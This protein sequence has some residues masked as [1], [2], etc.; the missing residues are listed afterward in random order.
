MSDIPDWIYKIY[1]GLNLTQA[2]EIIA[3][4]GYPMD[5]PEGVEEFVVDT[6]DRLFPY[7]PI[8]IHLRPRVNMVLQETIE[9]P[10]Y[11]TLGG[12]PITALQAMVKTKTIVY[13]AAKR[14]YSCWVEKERLDR[15]TSRGH[16]VNFYWWDWKLEGKK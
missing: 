2:V 5:W 1:G 16:W 12:R 13:K 15:K 7:A 14:G 9:E 3:S 10:D 6:E 8:V 4:Y 11:I